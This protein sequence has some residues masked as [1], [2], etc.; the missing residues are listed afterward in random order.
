VTIGDKRKLSVNIL[1]R[2]DHQI[3]LYDF[4]KLVKSDKDVIDICSFFENYQTRYAVDLFKTDHTNGIF[5]KTNPHISSLTKAIRGLNGGQFEKI[6]AIICK[7]LGFNKSYHAT[8]PSKDEGIDFIA[9]RDITLLNIDTKEYII[10]QSKHFTDTE[11][12]IKEIR[13]LSGSVLLFSRKEFSTANKYAKFFIG[14]FSPVFVLFVSNYFYSND[15]LTLCKNTS[16]VPIDLIDT[17]G[18][19]IRGINEGVLDWTGTSG[20]IDVTKLE[21]DINNVVIA[22]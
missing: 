13:E 12:T 21:R 8:Q 9:F 10:G 19:C 7:C 2:D 1:E 14:A 16:I 22:S 15:A 3:S 18:I 20:N 5:I 17:I 4:D 6:S 11:I